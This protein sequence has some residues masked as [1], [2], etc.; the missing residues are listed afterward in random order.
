MISVQQS[1]YVDDYKLHLTFNNGKRGVANLKET[2]FN[3]S[4]PIFAQLRDLNTFKQFK[5]DHGTITWLDELDLAPEY[6]FFVT[7]KKE[8]EFQ[9]Q[10]ESWGYKSKLH[11]AE[12]SE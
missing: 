10:F 7:F 6:L 3:D 11:I 1:E 9:K 8:D 12:Q 5:L 2:I 4:R